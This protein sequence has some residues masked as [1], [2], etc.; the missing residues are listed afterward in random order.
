MAK[1]MPRNLWALTMF[2]I[3]HLVCCTMLTVACSPPAVALDITLQYLSANNSESPGFDP[4]GIG[5][6]A[7]TLAAANHWESIIGNNHSMTIQF[8]YEDLPD[9]RLADALPLN[10]TNSRT[11]VGRIRFDTRDEGGVL[12]NWWFDNTPSEDEEYEMQHISYGIN[13]P[14]SAFVGAPLDGLEIGYRGVTFDGPAAGKFDFQSTALH[15][16]GHL[17]GINDTVPDADSEN[18]DGDYD[19]PSSLMNGD[20][21]AVRTAFGSPAHIRPGTALMCDECASEGLRRRPSAVDILAAAS[22]SNWTNIDFPRK[23]FVDGTNFNAA[24]NWLD[25]QAPSPSDDAFVTAE[26]SFSTPVELT[27]NDSVG[28]L[29]VLGTY[30]STGDHLL[31]VNGRTLIERPGLAFVS[32]RV[33]AGGVLNTDSLVV[34]SGG[35]SPQ[36]GAIF[37]AGDM[38]VEDDGSGAL[39]SNVSG[40]GLID[41]SG[42]LVNN[43]LIRTSGGGTLTLTSA[44]DTPLDLDGTS[45]DGELEVLNGDMIIE[46]ALADPF[47]DRI[48]VGSDQ[49]L[50]FDQP[51]VLGSFG[52]LRNS[53][54]AGTGTLSGAEATLHGDVVV[55]ETL[56]I[57]APVIFEPNSEISFQTGT[58]PTLVLNGPTTYRGPTFQPG[59]TMIQN[60]DADVESITAIVADFYDWDGI[61]PPSNT[62]VTSTTLEIHALQIETGDPALHGY[63]GVATLA[64]AN[65]LVTTSAA[66]RLDGTI[67]MTDSIVRGQELLNYG[68]IQGSGAILSDA[69]VNDGEVIASGGT[70]A[71]STLGLFPDLDGAGNAGRLR[72]GAGALHITGD[73]GAPVLFS[74]TLETR[75]AS[76]YRM[77]FHGLVNQGQISM[78]GGSYVAPLLQ[79][80]GT[81]EVRT[82]LTK[83]ASTLETN[84]VF[85]AGSST[86][87]GRGATLVIDGAAHFDPSAVIAGD[88]ELRLAVGSTATG[89][90]EIAVDVENRGNIAP[91]ASAGTFHVSGDY[92]QRSSGSL[93]L[94]I[95]GTTP[96]TEYDRLVVDGDASFAGDLFVELDPAY[97]PGDG[98]GFDLLDFARVN[99]EF[100]ALHF[101]M[102]P[103]GMAW[104]VSRLYLDG[105]VAIVG[106]TADFDLDGDVDAKD[107]RLWESDFGGPGSDADGDALSGGD[108]LLAW[109][110]E[111]G[112]GVIPAPSLQAVPEPTGA[113][114]MVCVAILRLSRRTQRAARSPR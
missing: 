37:V 65:L 12:R 9:N 72:A 98:D 57:D 8:W 102:L 83:V 75:P 17:L 58:P 19:L 64:N 80:E 22:A 103:A 111:F 7:Q 92:R 3:R 15:E 44:T 46:T 31:N 35:L 104:N 95:A 91:G 87:I 99:S 84:V 23:M 52:E 76:E 21:A 36:G 108:D 45:G 33:P 69:L 40:S 113:A 6:V 100:D 55:S 51:W 14:S 109:Q 32:L 81:L 63:G 20:V 71:I 5:I 48:V 25:S 77:D 34:R 39:D 27:A 54:V 26:G 89:D 43:G 62:T 1:S 96:G 97:L 42:T 74:G 70:L 59:G 18:D 10:F 53:G 88:G 68:V 93:V 107:L 90:A 30:L 78:T 47:D 73:P 86:D 11:T 79:H 112:L 41:V 60:G 110:K 13:E 94:E 2:R 56:L 24:G 4:F 38:T 16:I 67:D 50:Q 61:G 114:W 28:S 49:F 82:T 66:W 106:L 101:D 105:V 85:A 29:T